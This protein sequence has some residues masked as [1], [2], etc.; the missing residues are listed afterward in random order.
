MSCAGLQPKSATWNSP[1]EFSKNE[2]FTAAT[3]SGLE[4]GWQLAA[5]DRESGLVQFRHESRSL[6]ASLAVNINQSNSNDKIFVKTTIT[7]GGEASL[8]ITPGQ[9]ETDLRKYYKSFFNTLGITDKEKT[10]VE[11]VNG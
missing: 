6:V 11:M 7:Y 4:L 3:K 10:N 5:S 9:A 8:Y 2:I 1:I